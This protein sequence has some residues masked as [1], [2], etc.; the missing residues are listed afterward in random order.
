MTPAELAAVL[1]RL[2][3][4]CRQNAPTEFHY[5]RGSD[6]GRAAGYEYAARLIREE[7]T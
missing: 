3:A 1:D 2:A 5:G 7:L 6:I 4:E